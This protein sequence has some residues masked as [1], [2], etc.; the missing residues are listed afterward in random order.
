MRLRAFDRELVY[1]GDQEW[2]RI[3]IPADIPD[4]YDLT[5]IAE[6]ISGSEIL[7]IGLVCSGHQGMVLLDGW[8]GGVSGIELVDGKASSDNETTRR[9]F[10]FRNGE[11]TNVTCRV[12]KSSVIVACGKETITSDRGDPRRF[13][14]TPGWSIPH[15]DRLFIGSWKGSRY[16][17]HKVELF[18]NTRSV[19]PPEARSAIPY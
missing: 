3:E 4:E 7:T 11:P 18:P 1:D 2:G 14:L 8:G 5:I 9:G 13:P 17:I 10:R 19:A 6:R 16:R 12:R 15:E